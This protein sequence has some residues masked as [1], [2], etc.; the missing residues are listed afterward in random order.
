MSSQT[1]IYLLI[2]TMVLRFRTCVSF[3]ILLSSSLPSLCPHRPKFIYFNYHH[4]PI[5]LQ[6]IGITIFILIESYYN[7][8][9]GF[10]GRMADWADSLNEK[11]PSPDA[12]G[13]P[14][15]SGTHARFYT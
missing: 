10:C 2:N 15:S 4:W 9:Y 7:N 14:L 6:A 1:E 5:Q 3:S 12:T 8:L 11:Y 13:Y